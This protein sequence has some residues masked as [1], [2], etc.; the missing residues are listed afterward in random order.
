MYLAV[1][2]ICKHEKKHWYINN[3]SKSSI[4]QSLIHCRQKYKDTFG[5]RLKTACME[6]GQL[7]LT[8][9]LNETKCN[10][11]YERF[12]L[13]F[14]RLPYLI[15]LLLLHWRESN[16]GRVVCLIGH[17]SSLF[18]HSFVTCQW[19]DNFEIYGD[20]TEHRDV[21]SSLYQWY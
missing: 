2:D 7:K 5:W 17:S 4:E 9:Y 19:W 13:S 1:S 8:K 14:N 18:C 12:K 20:K 3:C 16:Y 15:T 11:K 21:D 10:I 6:T